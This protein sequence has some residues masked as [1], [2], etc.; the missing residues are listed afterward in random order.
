MYYTY[1]VQ[2]WR[3]MLPQAT[4]K[5][6]TKKIGITQNSVMGYVCNSHEYK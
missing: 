2:R 3:Q 1:Y 4:K 5:K 6:K